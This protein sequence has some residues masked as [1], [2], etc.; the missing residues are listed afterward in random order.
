MQASD[1]PAI[2]AIQRLC[3]PAHLIEPA[4]ALQSRRQRAPGHGWVARRGGQV[5]GYLFSHPWQRTSLPKL[6]QDLPALPPAPDCLFLHDLA[7]HPDGR[8][9]KVAEQL[10]HA[11]YRP[12]RAAGLRHG[13]L[14]AVEGADAFWARHGYRRQSEAASGLCGYG[15]QAVLMDCLL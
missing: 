7:V 4:A 3:Y 15:E 6:G 1:L 10:L 9:Q 13:R 14:V 8:G 11:S 5:L 2:L 12:A